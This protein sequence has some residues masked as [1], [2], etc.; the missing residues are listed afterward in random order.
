M[1]EEEKPVGKRP[2]EDGASKAPHVQ[3][4]EIWH[5]RSIIAVAV[6]AVAFVGGAFIGLPKPMVVVGAVAVTAAAFW[7]MVTTMQVF[8]ARGD[9]SQEE[10]GD[11]DAP[12]DS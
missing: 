6:I 9:A 7:L 12:R 3:K 4:A 11:E 1:N 2:L 8:I 5:R 10:D